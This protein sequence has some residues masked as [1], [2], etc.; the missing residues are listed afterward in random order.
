M[1]IKDSKKI[2]VIMLV[3]E[4][5][6]GSTLLDLIMD[7]HSQVVGVGELSHYSKH[8]NSG[9]LCSCGKQIKDCEFWQN[10]FRGVGASRL[11]L[12]YRK[13]LDFLYNKNEYFYYTDFEKKLDT[14]EYVRITEQVYKNILKFSGKE[15][16]FD[17]SKSCDRAE[18]IIKFNKNL[19]IILLHLV[20]DGRGVAYS[21]IKL[22]RQGFDFMRKWMMANLKTELVKSRNRNIKNIFVLY[23]DFV[24]NPEKVLKY[25]LNQLDL[26]F[27]NKMLSFGNVIHHQPGGNF[28]LRINAETDEI[29][30]DEKWRSKMSTKDKIVFNLLFSWLNLFYKLK[31]KKY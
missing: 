8:L 23:E 31:P 2:P 19:D 12:I 16:V 28:N 21:N 30:L 25:I 14:E 15:I 26:S 4:G 5:H 6:S 11:P 27:E 17:S 29:K 10:V 3:G 13:K 20:R 9:G 24:K 1:S 18:A 22:G 7:S